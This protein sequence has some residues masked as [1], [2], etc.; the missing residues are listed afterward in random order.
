MR[1]DFKLQKLFLLLI[2]SLSTL[3]GCIKPRPESTPSPAPSTIVSDE[4]SG[5][6]STSEASP[7]PSSTQEPTELEKK[8]DEFLTALRTNITDESEPN[9]QTVKAKAQEL[10]VL[11]TDR[12]D[13]AGLRTYLEEAI[14]SYQNP[15]QLFNNELVKDGLGF[16][17]LGIGDPNTL[18]IDNNNKESTAQQVVDKLNAKYRSLLVSP[19]TPSPTPSVTPTPT[20]SVTP[21]PTPSVTPTPTPSPSQ[22]NIVL[23]LVIS[24]L[25][26]GMAGTGFILFNRKFNVFPS[27]NAFLFPQRQPSIPDPQLTESRTTTGI[28]NSSREFDQIKANVSNH[29]YQFQEYDRKFQDKDQQ[30]LNLTQRVEILEQQI[31]TF[32]TPNSISVQ[33]ELSPSIQPQPRS[34]AIPASSVQKQIENPW[35][36]MI[37]QSTPVEDT[38]PSSRRM[39]SG[40]YPFFVETTSRQA[41]LGICQHSSGQYILLPRKSKTDHERLGSYFDLQGSFKG[42]EVEVIQPA[43]VIPNGQGWELDQKGIVEFR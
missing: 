1:S 20:P 38:N 16:P 36:Q 30:I 35:K 40:E 17:D 24:V 22:G 14:I 43:I 41:L 9:F 27:L 2:L 4:T 29:N 42:G 10:K 33:R 15:A 21:T 19:L 6:E 18:L 25:A 12:P 32:T 39:G 8:W 3:S 34:L 5:A 7:N 23:Q 26:L 31:K 11:A 28:F 13:L 37:S